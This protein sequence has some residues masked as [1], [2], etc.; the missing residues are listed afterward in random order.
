MSKQHH[1]KA[2]WT[3]VFSHFHSSCCVDGLLF[4][5][6]SKIF[7]CKPLEV[8]Y[9]YTV[10]TVDMLHASVINAQPARNTATLN[11]KGDK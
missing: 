4:L 9:K 3:N 11:K 10:K 7:H 2:F 8:L 6:K 1:L 5:S